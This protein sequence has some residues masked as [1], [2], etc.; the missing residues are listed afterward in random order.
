MSG[1]VVYGLELSEGGPEEGEL[2]ESV[3]VVAEVMQMDGTKTLSLCTSEPMTAWQQIGMLR[4][5]LLGAE[6]DLKECWRDGDDGA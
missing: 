3:L 1:E 6:M 2:V 4:A 5:A